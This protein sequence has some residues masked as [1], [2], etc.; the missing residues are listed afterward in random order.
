MADF[1]LPA[2][3]RYNEVPGRKYPAAA[4]AGRV[5]T[6]K[7]Y[8]WNADDGQNPSTDTYEIDLDDCGP[9]VLDA[10]I[11]IK[12]EQDPT[13]TFRRSCREGICGSCAMNV[14][15]KARWT[16]RTHVE[17]VTADGTLA[18]VQLPLAAVAPEAAPLI[19]APRSHR[20]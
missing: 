11:K 8:R 9:M 16:C 7:I 1:I 10:L 5:K 14:N 6:F 17:K 3:S 13:L 20:L 19:R 18:S 2:N 15:G 4:G 12:N